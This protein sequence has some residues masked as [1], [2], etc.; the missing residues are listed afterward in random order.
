[1]EVKLA[2]VEAL[3]LVATVVKEL[4]GE[5]PELFAVEVKTTPSES[6][7]VTS[8]LDPDGIRPEVGADIMGTW[9]VTT[10]SPPSELVIVVMISVN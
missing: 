9:V 10:I 1:M 4:A 5:E 8:W 6:V 2:L 7:F 3:V